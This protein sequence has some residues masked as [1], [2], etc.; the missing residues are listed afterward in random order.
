MQ[1]VVTARTKLKV[2]YSFEFAAAEFTE[3]QNLFQ[4]LCQR[5]EILD[6]TLY[7]LSVEGA[8]VMLGDKAEMIAMHEEMNARATRGGSNVPLQ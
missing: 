6:V 2:N 1:F 5:E 4:L 7:A 3:C 8:R